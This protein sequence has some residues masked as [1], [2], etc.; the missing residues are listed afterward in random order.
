MTYEIRQCHKILCTYV[1]RCVSGVCI[2]SLTISFTCLSAYIYRMLLQLK[3][4]EDVLDTSNIN[5]SQ[6][7]TPLHSQGRQ[8]LTWAGSR[9]GPVIARQGRVHIQRPKIT[10]QSQTAHLNGDSAGSYSRFM[11]ARNRVWVAVTRVPETAGPKV[12]LI[13]GNPICSVQVSI[14][15]FTV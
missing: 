9:G 12:M 3:F 1:Q 4:H 2:Y 14:T 7:C 13:R 6:Y 10:A 8:E 5:N 11:S 15:S